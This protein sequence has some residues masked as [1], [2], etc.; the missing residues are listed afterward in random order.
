MGWKILSCAL[1]DM[2]W[3]YSKIDS[4]VERKNN[5]LKVNTIKDMVVVCRIVIVPLLEDKGY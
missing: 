5:R 1:I 2:L 3:G 4:K